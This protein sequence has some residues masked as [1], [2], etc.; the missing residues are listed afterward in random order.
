MSRIVDSSQI[1]AIK[2]DEPNFEQYD[3]IE[4]KNQEDMLNIDHKNF[5]SPKV[6]QVNIFGPTESFGNVFPP[7][8]EE[9]FD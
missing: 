1:V 2:D 8:E 4:I 6:A 9:K 7:Y 5:E 3:K